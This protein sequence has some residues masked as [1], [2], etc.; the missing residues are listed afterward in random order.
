MNLNLKQVW[1]QIRELATVNVATEF[2]N[3]Q[4]WWNDHD[5][6]ALT[7]NNVNAINSRI[8][9]GT[10]TTL[11]VTTGSIGALTSTTS[12]VLKGTTTNDSAAAGNIGEIISSTI[13]TPT[14]F[15]LTGVYGDLTSISVTAGDWD[16]SGG[17]FQ[18]ANAATVTEVSM[19]ISTTTGN[20]TA[21][22]VGGDN[23]IDGIGA[24]TGTRNAGYVVASYRASLTATTTYYLKY[25][26]NFTVA[27]PQA[28]GR[29]SARRVR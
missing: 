20:S 19:G 17:V 12:T 26:S 7:W 2:I 6:G 13:S 9:T 24:V 10:V 4:K 18:T 25:E 3:F 21:G 8:T 29:I 5:S 11:T 14:N 28:V 23:R 22:L 1:Q 16:I 27:T 15:P